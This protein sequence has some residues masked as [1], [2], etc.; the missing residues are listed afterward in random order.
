M[1]DQ[2][3]VAGDLY[4]LVGAFPALAD[5][6]DGLAT[7]GEYPRHG[8]DIGADPVGDR[9]RRPAVREVEDPDVVTGP[10]PRRVRDFVE[11]RRD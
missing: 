6:V 5:D 9:L 7:F 8:R 3:A 4:V 10:R 2:P 1:D 11:G